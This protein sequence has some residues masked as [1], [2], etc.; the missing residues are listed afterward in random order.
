MKV[1]FTPVFNRKKKVNDLGKAPVEIRVYQ[2]RKR[3][4]FS[5]SIFLL[6][7][8]WDEKKLAV[9]KNHS[10][11]DML[12][13]QIQT[14]INE[15]ERI[16]TQQLVKGKTVSINSIT[17]QKKKNGNES[18][19][20]FVEGEVEKNQTITEK[21]KVSHRNMLNK[22]KEFKKGDLLFSDI[23][24]NFIDDYLN[25]LRKQKLADNTIHKQHKT[26][27]QYIELAIRKEYFDGKN[28]CKEF[29]VQIKQKKREVL[30]IAELDILEKLDLSMYDEKIQEVR[31]M[32]LFACYTGLRISDVTNLKPDFVKK[33]NGYSLDFISIKSKKRAEIPLNSLFKIKE[34]TLSRPERIL[35]KY[36]D[37][38]KKFIFQSIS[39]QYINRHLKLIS[40][41]AVIPIKVTF[42]IA[43]HTFGTYMASKSPLPQLMYLM[44][45][46]DIKTTMIYVNINQEL[47]RQG[48]LKVEWN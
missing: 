5:T 3:K 23:D 27:K 6:P 29:K 12:N 28:P 30:S 7:S 8:E 17:N 2:N 14:L 36:F 32:F 40:E 20:D 15:Y 24:Y 47:V 43:R 37:R 16:Q 45:H 22:L 46:S 35:E 38:D 26:L 33:D 4:F 13:I 9:N 39:E 25:D 10:G 19:I 34:Q 21:T 44:Q 42:H 18:F 48:L 1:V 41:K 11:A 31:D